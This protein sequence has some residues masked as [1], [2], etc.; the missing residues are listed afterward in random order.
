MPWARH[1]QAARS[2]GPWDTHTPRGRDAGWGM[3]RRVGAA[4]TASRLELGAVDLREGGGGDGLLRKVVE[5]LSERH[6]K[7]LLDR[8][9]RRLGGEALDVVLQHRELRAARGEEEERGTRGGA[10]V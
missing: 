5:E 1:T 6:A 10:C 7:L 3:W 9:D 2:V 8:R 4:R